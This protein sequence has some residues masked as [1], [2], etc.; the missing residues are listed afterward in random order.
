MNPGRTGTKAAA[1]YALTLPAGGSHIIRLRLTES[2]AASM[3]PDADAAL[4]SGFDAILDLRRQE[5]D[6][7]Y[8]DVIPASLD[9]D[10]TLV[11]SAPNAPR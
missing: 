1:H 9:A 11:M 5:A 3:A 10:S 4:G 7:F 6:A 2:A 8:A